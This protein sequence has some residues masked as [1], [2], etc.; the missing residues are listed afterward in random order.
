MQQPR[1]LLVIA[2]VLLAGCGTTG[3]NWF[4]PGP[5]SYQQAAAERFDPYP[6]NEAGPKVEGSRPR[7]YQKAIP[8]VDRSRWTSGQT[9]FRGGR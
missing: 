1:L 5:A 6:E 3:P 7:E 2:S 9:V 8:E 4:R